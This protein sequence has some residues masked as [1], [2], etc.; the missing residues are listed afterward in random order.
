MAS[1]Y[2]RTSNIY[3]SY[4]AKSSDTIADGNGTILSAVIFNIGT[5]DI[6][7]QLFDLNRLPISGDVPSLSIPVYNSNGVS[8]LDSTMLTEDGHVFDTGLSWGSSTSPGTYV[9]TSTPSLGVTIRWK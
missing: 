4:C 7:W 8:E 2:T 3:T 1:K 9:P 5:S 6:Y